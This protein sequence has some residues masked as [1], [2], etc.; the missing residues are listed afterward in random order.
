MHVMNSLPLV[1]DRESDDDGASLMPTPSTGSSAGT[2]G[3]PS[4]SPPP[5]PPPPPPKIPPPPPPP[6]AGAGNSTHGSRVKR[7]VRSFFWK[8]IPEEKVRGRA[9]IWTLSMRQQQ[10]YQIDMR[11]I[12]ELFGQ[13]ED[14]RDGVNQAGWSRR[15]FRETKEEIH[16]LDSKRSMNVGIFLKQFKRSNQAII[17]DIRHGNSKLYGQEAL[18][19]LLKLLPESDEV[20]KLK[21]FKGDTSKLSLADSFMYQLIQVPSFDVR[22]EAMVLKEEFPQ[23]CS[24]MNHEI[25]VIRLATKELMTCEELHAILHLVLQA[26]NIMNAGGYAGNAVGFKLSSLLSMADTKANKPGMNLLHFVALE[27]QKKDKNLLRFPEKL[28]QVHS[29][30]RISVDNIEAEL[31][32]LQSRTVSAEEKVQRN[33][34]LLQQVERFLQQSKKA[35]EE[36]SRSWLDLRREGNVLIDFFCEDKDTFKLDECFR[37]F[38]DFCQKFQK[39]VKDNQEQEQKEMARQRRLLE[40]EEK[41]HSWASADRDSGGSAFGRSSSENDVKTLSQDSLLELLRLRPDSPQGMRRSASFK[42]SRQS[43]TGTAADRQLQ[44]YLERGSTGEPIRFDSLPRSGRDPHRK[45]PVWLTPPGTPYG[46]LDNSDA[47]YG[48]RFSSGSMQ[49]TNLTRPED[50]D[51]RATSYGPINVSVER[52]VMA[53]KLQGFDFISHNNNHNLHVSG[54]VIGVTPETAVGSLDAPPSDTSSLTKSSEGEAHGNVWD[55]K[56]DSSQI[57]ASSRKEDED[58]STISSTT[59]DVPLPTDSAAPSRRNTVLHLCGPETDCSVTLDNQEVD[60]IS[61]SHDG[62]TT[63]A[64]L[65]NELQHSV[66]SHNDPRCTDKSSPHESAAS[67]PA[68]TDKP[69]PSASTNATTTGL[70]SLENNNTVKGKHTQ[71]NAALQANA[72]NAN[73]RTKLACKN[74]P[75]HSRVRTLHPSENQN[76]RKVVTTSKLNRTPSTASKS[77]N[78][79]SIEARRPQR[80]QSTPGRSE[81]APQAA[82][83]ASLPLEEPRPQGAT[84]GVGISHRARDVTSRP[85]SIHKPKPKVTRVVPR[86]PPEEKMCRSTMRALAQAQAQA[87]AQAAPGSGPTEAATPKASLPGFARNTVASSS[88][89][90][91]SPV[92]AQRQA[93]RAATPSSHDEKG[94]GPLRRVHSLRV[95]K[96]RAQPGEMPP[97]SRERQRKSSGSF[98]DKSFRSKDSSSGRPQRP[99]WK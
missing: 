10:H 73:S 82:R 9:N 12:E 90:M 47:P 97:L 59:C 46:R 64:K 4:S 38:Q 77:E 45:S 87:Q 78:R 32:S 17:D 53:P 35:L 34:E 44:E 88:R 93:A 52:H 83:R 67:E 96:A 98:S 20:K 27:A 1:S 30:V 7:R 2:E 11:T 65:P 39:A 18:K 58:N 72:T 49:N 19:E 95:P 54:Q 5:P 42:R 70:Q 33:T 80:D 43:P 23:L 63:G 3:P 50:L 74:S 92:A 22:I 8:P 28:P 36:L 60:S 48:R 57:T 79:V 37:I 85:P 26:G 86:P 81:K 13:R 6:L 14:G 31:H 84:A 25:D 66:T 94:Q 68:S 91:S 41:R 21:A 75:S 89:R 69:S 99:A 61:D 76:M 24:A 16:I 55:S 71:K 51:E 56:R 62:F 15:S 29:A 40:L